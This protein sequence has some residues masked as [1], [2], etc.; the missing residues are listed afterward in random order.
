M[1][2]EVCIVLSQIFDFPDEVILVCFGMRLVDAS[3]FACSTSTTNVWSDP[4]TLEKK[5]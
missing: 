3:K 1:A 4:I 5:K 2:L